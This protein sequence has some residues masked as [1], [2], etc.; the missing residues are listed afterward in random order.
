MTAHF[1]NQIFGNKKKDS[2]TFANDEWLTRSL[3]Y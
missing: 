3:E 2:P 1:A